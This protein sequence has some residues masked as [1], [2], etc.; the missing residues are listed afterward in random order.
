MH[1]NGRLP[2]TV[3]GEFF[4]RRLDLATEKKELVT[5]IVKLGGTPEL[6]VL[7]DEMCAFGES[8]ADVLPSLSLPHLRRIH[9]RVVT[10]NLPIKV[11]DD[12]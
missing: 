1:R 11:V 9:A 8:I 6:S 4:K 10:G 3:K 2:R 5:D 12:L 7:E